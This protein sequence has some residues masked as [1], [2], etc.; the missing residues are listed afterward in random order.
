MN[1]SSHGT[2]FT[3]QI[4]K[5]TELLDRISIQMGFW[6]FQNGNWRFQKAYRTGGEE[7]YYNITDQKLNSDRFR[8]FNV[9][10]IHQRVI[11]MCETLYNVI[12]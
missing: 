6:R 10:Y 9:G 11:Q 8:L 3:S 4:K 2:P 1:I 5:G 12:L 7:T